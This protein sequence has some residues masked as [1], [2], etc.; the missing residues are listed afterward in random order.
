MYLN[1]LGVADQC[2]TTAFKKRKKTLA[3]LICV[4]VTM[5]GSHYYRNDS[6]KEFLHEHLTTSKMNDLCKE[7]CA[8]NGQ[9]QQKLHM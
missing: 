1:T 4:E 7:W 3:L 6:H 2:L 5:K 8:S 9:K